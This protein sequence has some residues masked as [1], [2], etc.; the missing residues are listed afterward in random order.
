MFLV[1]SSIRTRIWLTTCCAIK[2]A[3]CILG[4]CSSCK[5]FLKLN[6]IFEGVKCSKECCQKDVDCITLLH[7]VKTKQ[8][9][10]VFYK[11]KGKEKKKISLVDKDLTFEDFTI[12]IKQMKGFPQHRFNVG[13]TKDAYEHAVGFRG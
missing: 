5:D 6:N 11:H 9:E 1:I 7:T 4:R 10:K 8:F 13:H 12:F 3:F 2:A